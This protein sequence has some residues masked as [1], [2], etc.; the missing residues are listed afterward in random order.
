MIVET[1]DDGE[2]HTR[3][4]LAVSL[5]AAGL[6]AGGTHVV[7][8][9]MNAEISQ[10]IV[11][12]PMRG[13]QHTYVRLDSVV[14]APPAQ[15][16]D[17]LLALAARRYARGHGPFRDKDLAWWS[18]LTLTDSRRAIELG[19]LR[20][21]DLDGQSYWM[22]DEPVETEVPTVMLLSNF[23]EY[24]SYARDPEDYASVGDTAGELMR[25]S[26]LLV[27]DGRLA[28]SWTRNVKATVVDIEVRSTPGI[29][30]GLRTA[31]ELEALAYG[32]FLGREPRLTL[33]T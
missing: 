29:T 25:S 13:K 16:R 6:E 8:Q 22:H 28:G 3:A 19:G 15:P 27:L 2:P 14:E 12:G 31:L 17:E 7:H 10:L 26:G 4:E 20:P 32:E 24:I 23:D 9:V 33:A 5:G 30:G 18:S 21:L 11:N 1:L